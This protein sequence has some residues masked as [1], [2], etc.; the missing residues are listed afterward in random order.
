MAI[1]TM[2]HSWA[3]PV[4]IASTFSCY[5]HSFFGHRYVR[6]ENNT[7]NDWLMFSSMLDG[8][9]VYENRF[10]WNFLEGNRIAS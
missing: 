1:G 4:H 10:E 6:Y 2:A 8:S 9:L 3:I 5:V 7:S